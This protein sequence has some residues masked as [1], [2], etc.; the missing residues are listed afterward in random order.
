MTRATIRHIII[1]I[2]AGFLAVAISAYFMVGVANTIA[3]ANNLKLDGNFG[4]EYGIHDISQSNNGSLPGLPSTTVKLAI[5]EDS[6]GPDAA[7]DFLS[8]W[9]SNNNQE[10]LTNL[11]ITSDNADG[12]D[13][14]PFTFTYYAGS[15][16]DYSDKTFT[17]AISVLDS[18][19]ANGYTSLNVV[20]KPTP[21][22]LRTTDVNAKIPEPTSSYYST[23]G[24]P[25][26]STSWENLVGSMSGAPMSGGRYNLNLST[27]G[28]TGIAAVKGFFY[29]KTSLKALNVTND[30]IWTTISNYAKDSGFSFLKPQSVTYDI[31]QGKPNAGS[32]DTA[33]RI[34]LSGNQPKSQ[35]NIDSTINQFKKAAATTPDTL[36]YWSQSTTIRYANNETPVFI[37]YPTNMEW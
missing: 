6:S 37:Q 18:L 32:N 11:V 19:N 15:P 33:V 1:L 25:E 21:D 14:T 30:K 34:V 20:S 24:D 27:E 35:A 36:L 10:Q 3:G 17:K 29:D 7:L 16:A 5:T 9:L 28:K 13:A 31:A 23:S 2:L 26:L 8:T 12:S 4:A 22:G